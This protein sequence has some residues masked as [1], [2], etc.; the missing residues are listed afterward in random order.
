MTKKF[1]IIS[2]EVSGDLLGS[3]L[4]KE[5]R[6]RFKDSKEELEFT[7]VGGKL[8]K[9]EG[10]SS[11]FDMEELCV[12][13]FAEVLPHIPKLLKRISQTAA[14]IRKTKPDYVITIDS[15][16]FSFRVMKKLKNYHECKKTHLI[17]PSVWTYRAGR[18]KKIAK[19]YD[20][21]LAILPFEP[22]YFTKHGLKTVFIGSPIVE[23]LPDF[24]KKAQINNG[25]RQ[26]YNLKSEDILL[27]VT[28]GSRNF[29]VKNIFPH[30]IEAINLLKND[31]ENLKIVIST[32]DKTRKLVE[33]MAQEI[34]AEYIL[35]KSEEKDQSL[36]SCNFAM[37][38]SGTNTVEISLHKIPLL[39][40]YKFNALTYFILDKIVTNRF[41]NLINII[42]NKYV[43]KEF[44]QK[45][46][47]GEKIAKSMNE[48]ILNPKIAQKQIDDCEEALKIMA[49]GSKKT[50]TQKAVDAILDIV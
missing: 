39:V 26:K 9:N 24:T 48:L 18:A 19:L 33:E 40:C 23:N 47:T 28:P 1:F 43:I 49:M 6:L 50:S 35:V 29:E 41:A 15:P 7:G 32:V 11:I 21:L 3:K 30:F 37:A 4:I 8:M 20:L 44:I 12:M 17:A 31:V 27:Y 22:P 2:G 45:D 36:M 14:E 13:G 25:F 10:F 5:I 34:S 42:M 38:K 16:D 46:C